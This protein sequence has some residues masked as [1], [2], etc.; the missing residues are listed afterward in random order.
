VHELASEI[1]LR[2][3]IELRFYP[4]N[5]EREGGIN[6]HINCGDPGENYVILV[7]DARSLVDGLPFSFPF[8]VEDRSDIPDDGVDPDDCP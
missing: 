1:V 7:E 6:I 8:A 2:E 5:V 4:Q 3:V